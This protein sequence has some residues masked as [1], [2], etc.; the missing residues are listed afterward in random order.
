MATDDADRNDVVIVTGSSGLLGTRITRRLA[1][2]FQV[3]GMDVQG[4][5][6]TPPAME[7]VPVDLTDDDSV[8]AALGRVRHA[9]GPRI[10]SVI[11]LAAFVDF[12]GEQ[13]P[14]YEKV[15]V[16]GTR[17]LLDVLQDFDVEQFVFSSTM[18]V[19]APVEPG[20]RITEEDP[21]DPAWAYPQ[22]KVATEEIVDEHRG[23]IPAV[24]LRIAGV[25][26]DVGHSPPV[27]NQIK[28][29]HDKRFV[30]H[31]YPADLNKGQA[32]LHMDDLVEAVVALIDH[33]GDLPPHLP[34][35]LGEEQV[36]G[37]G[38]LQNLIGQELH[39]KNW[40]TLPV[41]D[42][43]AKAGAA[44]RERNPLGEDPFIKPWMVERAHDHYALDTSRARELLG[45]RPQ[46][47]LRDTI[48]KMI[49]ALKAD[50]AGWYAENGLEPPAAAED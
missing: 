37:Y 44:V 7:F 35:L 30:S 19:H 16:D 39:G 48:P 2:R 23:K 27:T 42:V 1:D 25:Y 14:L 31:F 46:H 38:E 17:R 43:A 47:S 10:A 29:I 24:V 32:F 11:H 28:R 15:T 26:D 22:S 50:P 5:P 34:L 18:L 20:D 21:L 36:M 8:D 13:S 12:S 4:D 3:I 6:T 45:W 33:R 49:A 41:P 9:Y 40:T